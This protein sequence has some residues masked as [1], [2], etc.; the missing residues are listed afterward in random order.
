MVG[1]GVITDWMDSGKAKA[2]VEAAYRSKYPQRQRPC[3]LPYKHDIAASEQWYFVL[4]FDFH[5]Q[6]PQTSWWK[7]SR[8]NFM[9]I[10]CDPAPGWPTE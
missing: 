1:M 2:A 9:P 4:I 8:S 10:E 6:V 3:V 7:I 5:E